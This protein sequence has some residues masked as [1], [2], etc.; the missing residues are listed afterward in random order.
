MTPRVA[1]FHDVPALARLINRAYQIERFFMDSDRTDEAEVRA[2]VASGRGRFLVLDGAGD[3]APELAAAVWV[4][5]RGDRGYFGMLSVDPALKGRRLGTRMVAAAEEHCRAAG[6]RV[7]DIL[8]VNL[9]E[10]LFPW[11]RRLGFV[12]GEAVPFTDPSMLKREAHLVR[13]SKPL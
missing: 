13:M 2:L 4:E 9:R 10:E 8:V 1:T 6:C 7:L 3:A 12:P 11:Y 5:P